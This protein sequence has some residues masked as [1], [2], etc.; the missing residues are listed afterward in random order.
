MA[1]LAIRP[2]AEG[3]TTATGLDNLPG[4]SK[5]LECLGVRLADK[6]RKSMSVLLLTF[7]VCFSASPSAARD[8]YVAA[9]GR[10]AWSGRFAEPRADGT[11]GP[12]ATLERARDELRKRKAAGGAPMGPVTVHVRGG[13]YIRDRA[14]ELTAEDSGDEKAPNTYR[15]YG[16]EKVNLIGGKPVKEFK[17]V[18]DAAVLKRLDESARGHVVQ[19]N[20]KAAGVVDLG[21]AVAPG[22]RIELF[23]NGQ[24]MT[25]ARWPNEGFA[26][27]AGV[28]GGKPIESHGIKGDAVGAFTYEGDRPRRWTAENDIRL[29]G[30]WFWDWADAYEKVASLD[31]D[32]RVISTVPPYHGY[33]YRKGARWYAVNLLA[34]LDRPGE[35]YL[36]R[37]TS[38]LYFWPPAATEA[39]KAFVSVLDEMVRMNS[40]SHVTIRG[41]TLAFNR[42]TAVNIRG[43]THCLIDACTIKNVGGAAVTIAGGTENGVTGCDIHNIGDSGISLSGGDRKTLTPGRHYAIDNHIHHYS[44]AT[45]TYRTAVSAA[46]VGNRIAH[47]LMHDAPHMAIG[48]SGNE[49]VIEFNEVHTVCMDTDDA[50]AL[51][52][53]RDWTWRGNVIRYNYFHHVGRFKGGI[54]VQSV[55]LDDWASGSTVFGNVFYKAGRGVLVGGGRDNTVE[56]NIFVDCTPAVHV[57]SRGLGWARSYFDGRDNTLIERLN[58]VPYKVPPWSARYPELLKLYDDEPAVAKGNQVLR[59]ICVGGRWLDLHDGLTEKVVHVADNLVDGDPHFVDAERQNF[60]LKGDSPAFKLGFQRIPVEQIGLQKNREGSSN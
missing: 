27:T 13:E 29:H 47:N 9:N 44:R 17:P 37:K 4:D 53:G 59:N 56:N 60:Q 49:H 35:W 51:Y 1:W 36:D 41:V 28:V 39:G 15:A 5:R 20:L 30:Y 8:L 48:L 31:V 10:D 25:L 3:F 33:G 24:P 12:F 55:Y 7:A 43:G 32:K 26:R 22:R 42:G 38:T 21:D 14:F 57:D 45:Q 58:A 54:G 40:T 6:G 2:F 19:A 52:M 46:G 23:F 11:D 34:E 16:N 50:G 18:T